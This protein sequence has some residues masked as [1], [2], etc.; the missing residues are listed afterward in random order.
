MSKIWIIAGEASGDTYG[1]TLAKSL[2]ALEPGIELGG[3]GGEKMRAAGVNT[4]VD[5]TE[6]GIVG[7]LEALR[8]LPFFIRLLRRLTAAAAE[9]R[10]DT[11]VMI[12]YPG[13]NLPF[14]K[15][16]HK[17]GIRVVWYISPQVWAWRTGRIWKLAKCC[18][19]MLCIF[20]FEPECYAPTSLKAEFVGH[21]LLD[22]LRPYRENLPVRDE[23]HILLLPGSRRMEL[24]LLLP[25]MIN[26]AC[27]MHRRNPALRFE[28]ALPRPAILELAREIHSGMTL[29]EDAPEFIW[30]VGSTRQRMCEAG[31]AIAASGTVTIEA[32]LLGLPL[33]VA[34]KL[35]SLSWWLASKLIRINTITIANLVCGSTVY[36]ECLQKG[37]TPEALAEAAE[38]LLP[39]K[40]GRE[41]CLQ[42]IAE[43]QRRMG[44]AGNVADNVARI[45]LKLEENR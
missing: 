45:A 8:H 24:S 26:A 36:Q 6:L 2:Q 41:Q 1:A 33:V 21:P 9:A 30:S 42:G 4:L 13:F 7:I 18:D 43:F 3:M 39:G 17:L 19:R 23:N 31:A 40:P 15:R 20:P 16:L 28:I 5:S 25:D 35:N 29:P 32:A 14:A 34:Y 12:D 11:V 38:A 27:L 22:D 10:P 37:C 44:Q